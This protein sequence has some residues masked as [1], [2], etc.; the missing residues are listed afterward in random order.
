M[1]ITNLIWPYFIWTDYVLINHQSASICKISIICGKTE[2]KGNDQYL[3]RSC[4]GRR[5]TKGIL[6]CPCRRPV[7]MTPLTMDLQHKNSIFLSLSLLLA[8]VCVC[9]YCRMQDRIWRRWSWE[10]D[11]DLFCFCNW[12]MMVEDLHPVQP[13]IWRGPASSLRLGWAGLGLD[14]VQLQVWD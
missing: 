8:F 10:R 5:E 3:S 4:K 1:G 9:F 12:L 2:E 11:R 14:E 7:G 13:K 6:P